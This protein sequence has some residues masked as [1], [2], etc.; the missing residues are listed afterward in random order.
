MPNREFSFYMEH[1]K[2]PQILKKLLEGSGENKDHA[3]LGDEVGL[4]IF[5]LRFHGC[6]VR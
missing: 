2:F 3:T 4:R 6:V 1:G 5:I